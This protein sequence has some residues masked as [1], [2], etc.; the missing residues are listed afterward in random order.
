MKLNS[1]FYIIMHL[2]IEVFAP[3]RGCSMFQLVGNHCTIF[4]NA[5]RNIFDVDDHPRTGG[6][7][8]VILNIPRW[9]RI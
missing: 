8:E 9:L 7:I 4:L 1:N 3:C 6:N 5:P 2:I